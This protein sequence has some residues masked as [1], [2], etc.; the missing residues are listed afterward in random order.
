MDNQFYKPTVPDNRRSAD[1]AFRRPAWAAG[2][3]GLVGCASTALAWAHAGDAVSPEGAEPKVEV[4]AQRLISRPD[5]EAQAEGTVVLQRGTVRIFADRVAYDVP[6]D[7]ARALGQ[8]R[9]ERDG[10]VYSGPELALQVQRFEGYFLEPRF[11]FPER[12]TGGSASRIDFLGPSRARV[13]DARYTSCPLD[14]PGAPGWV[15]QARSVVLDEQANEG[16]ATGG[17]LRFLGV[18]ILYWPVLSFPLDDARKSGWLPPDIRIDNRSGIELSVP[19]YWNIAPNRD[20]TLAPRLITRR[21]L[22]LDAEFRYLEPHHQGQVALDWLP[23]DRV[24]GGSRRGLAWTHSSVL[25]AGWR[26]QAELVRVSDPEWWKDFPDQATS[27]TPRLLPLRAALERPWQTTLGDGLVYLRTHRWQLLQSPDS[28]IAAPYERELQLGVQFAGGLGAWQYALETE[29]NRFGLPSARAEGDL[30]RPGERLHLQGEWAYVLRQ[31]GWW[32]IPRV[33]LNAARYDDAAVADARGGRGRVIPSF[34]LD[35]GLE[36][37][38]STQAFGRPLLQTLE[39]RLRYVYTPFR[40]QAGYAHYDA[41]GRDFSFATLFADNAFAGVDRVSDAH[42]IT[43]G[44]TSRM[45]DAGSGA[46]VLRL[47]LAQRYLLRTQR[48][49]AQPDGSPDGA[50]LSQSLSD[51]LLLASTSVLPGWRLEGA[52]QYSPEISRSIRSIATAQ[53]SP[54]PFRTVGG[55]YRFARG[56][57]EQVEL[58]WQWPLAGVAADGTAARRVG[59]ACSSAWYSVG[60]V[61]YSLKDSRVTDSVLGLEYD[62]GCWILRLVAMRLST[63]R[64]EATTRLGVQLELAGFSRLNVGSNP[65]QVLKD[66]IPGYRLLREDP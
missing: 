45:L 5:V 12:G 56:L 19:Y 10:A 59:A 46:E 49:T 9:V 13:S 51:A 66:N 31:D 44:F 20:A 22:G 29:F 58:G 60:R 65:L 47:G 33:A 3:L 53:F 34:S 48:V 17:V 30:R 54:G 63:G 25:D 24:A 61:N 43:A 52:L 1:L 36:L 2:L 39:P 26:A 14:G 8:V 16:V 41:V 40:E 15:L 38:R 50:P 32:L 28:V 57:N 35:S 64:S 7:L 23:H 21:G 37:E 6:L 18:P 4:Q 27:T 62:A 42:Q 11:E 55:T